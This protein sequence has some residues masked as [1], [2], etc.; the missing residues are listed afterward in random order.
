MNKQAAFTLIELVLVIVVLA[1]L[2]SVA[3]PK[4][5][6]LKSDAELASMKEMRAALV[7]AR[8]LNYA[9]VEINPGN[10]NSNSTIYTKDNG[11]QFRIRGNYPDGRW[12]NNGIQTFESLVS[13]DD[14]TL[15]TTSTCPEDG[16]DWCV[17]HK[18]QL[19]FTSRQ[20]SDAA[21]G[22]GFV[23]FPKGNNFNQIR[24]YVYYFTPNPSGL[25]T[26][27]IIPVVGID[28]SECG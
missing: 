14:V 9:L 7:S 22:H 8:D 25:S 20:Y 6:N 11:E 18:G 3:I 23:I 19:W 16:S 26:T 10:K 13:F 12:V 2:S 21:V 28:S 15:I 27:G 24:C 17:H 5:I 4:F 1:I